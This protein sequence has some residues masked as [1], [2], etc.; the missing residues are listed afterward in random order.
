L[1]IVEQPQDESG[2]S[3]RASG[4]RKLW[5]VSASG[6]EATFG[7]VKTWRL[8]PVAAPQLDMKKAG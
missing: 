3:L 2:M 6:P 7:L 4:L 1:F 8:R 5:P